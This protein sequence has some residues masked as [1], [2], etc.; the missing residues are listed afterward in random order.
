MKFYYTIIIAVL[1]IA[2]FILQNIYPSITDEYSLTSSQV[3]EKPWTI[4]TSIFLHGSVEHLFFN[5]FALILFGL[6]LEN[7][8]GS[9]KFLIVYFVA[10]IF[11]SLGALIYTAS[12]GASGAIF[13]IL[14]CLAL[15]RPRATVYVYFAP[16]PMIAAV[17]VWILIDLFGLFIPSGI[18]NMA[19]IVGLIVGVIIGYRLRKYYGQPFRK[20]KKEKILTEEEIDN[21]EREYIK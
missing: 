16:M 21:W 5:M 9:R 14:G 18:A 20:R 15:L 12:L 8:I 6:I 10:G 4:V 2:A 17:V 1:C 13:G 7:I 19:H 11:A 3:L